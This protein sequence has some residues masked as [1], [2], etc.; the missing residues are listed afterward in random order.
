MIDTIV[1]GATI[2]D[3]CAGQPFVTDVAI[4]GD[5]IALL[6]NLADRE[7]VERVGGTGLALAPGFIDVHSHSDELWLVDPR[8][9]G[10]IAQGVTTEI[11]GNCGRAAAPRAGDEPSRKTFDAFFSAID[12]GGV[13]VNVASLVGLGTTRHEIHGDRAGRL[14]D[15][16]LVA[17]A[18][19]V[20]AGVEQGA[21][22]VSSGLVYAPSRFADPDELVALAS[23][24]RDAGGARYVTHLRNEGDALLEAVGEA[25]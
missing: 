16:A 13:A 14:D 2:L 7:A 20:R 21:L 12:R 18:A 1:A 17:Q 3:G 15:A 24:A 4:V 25:V 6:G 22:G 11:G 5:R 10:K 9:A 23:A 8:C 19:L